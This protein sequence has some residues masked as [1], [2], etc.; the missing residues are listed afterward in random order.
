MVTTRYCIP[1]PQTNLPT[2]NQLSKVKVTMAKV[3]SRSH[4]TAFH[5]LST[6]N[7]FNFG[8][9]INI[10]IIIFKIIL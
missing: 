5:F 7:W 3:K 10:H 1:T 9:K 8:E 2:Q 6:F 4:S